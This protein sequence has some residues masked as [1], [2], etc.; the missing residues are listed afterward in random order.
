MMTVHC[1]A[2]LDIS[3]CSV[4]LISLAVLMCRFSKQ[5]PV[6]TGPERTVSFNEFR[7]I[8]KNGWRRHQ[9]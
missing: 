9:Q 8:I 4:P 2:V 6:P 1:D 3:Q 7:Q 5:T